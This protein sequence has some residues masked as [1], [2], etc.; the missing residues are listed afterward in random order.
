MA[1]QG[2]LETMSLSDL[3]QFIGAGRKSGT[4]KFDGGNITKQ[5]YFQEGL[6]VGC[7]SNNPREYLGQILLHY[8]KV[9]EEQLQTARETQRKSHLKLGDALVQLG[10][11]TEADVFDA[12]KTRTLEA[13]YDLFVWNEGQFEFYDE[14]P[15]PRDLIKVEVEP[16]TAIMEAICRM[17]EIARFRTLVPSDRAIVELLPGWTSSLNLGKDLR[18]MLFFVHKRMSV[19]E[20]AYHMHASIFQIY[21]LLFELVSEGYARVV[22]E[23][24]ESLGTTVVDTEDVPETATE[25]MSSAERK[26]DEDP[27]AAL[28]ILQRVLKEEP[29]NSRAQELVIEAEAK[30]VHRIFQ[31]ELSPHAIPTLAV[32]QDNL[33]GEELHPQE[34]FLLSR[35]NGTWDVQSILSICPFR[36]ADSLMMM[37]SLLARGIIKLETKALKLS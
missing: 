17:D 23:S 28:T 32:S 11:L 4:L 25:L 33:A 6:I 37:R 19:A 27:E 24:A 10:F 34:G 12:V 18:R 36:E 8:G 1:I 35:I 26:V 20:I 21:G 29:K 5:V 16:T 2:T 7:R 13:I 31:S 30:L 3:F 14:E 22:G 15:P 9:N